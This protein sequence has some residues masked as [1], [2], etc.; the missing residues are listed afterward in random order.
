MSAEKVA[1]NFRMTKDINQYVTEEASTLGMSKN[2]FLLFLI[3]MYKKDS[4]ESSQIKLS[5][6]QMYQAVKEQ[7][8]KEKIL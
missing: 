8:E 3:A 2:S 7:I 6:E 5:N 1:F 4:Q